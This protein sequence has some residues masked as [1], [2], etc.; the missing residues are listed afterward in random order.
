MKTWLLEATDPGGHPWVNRKINAGDVALVVT[1]LEQDGFKVTV[2]RGGDFGRLE[3]QF[4]INDTNSSDL[5]RFVV[6]VFAGD[7]IENAPRI[8]HLQLGHLAGY[9]RTID[10]HLTSEDDRLTIAKHFDEVLAAGRR[11]VPIHRHRKLAVLAIYITLA[12]LWT[13]S[14]VEVWTTWPERLLTALIGVTAAAFWVPRLPHSLR[15][16]QTAIYSRVAVRPQSRD[17]WRQHRWN[18]KRDIWAAM[19]G[20]AVTIVTA[21]VMGW[22]E[23]S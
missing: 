17:E 19:L 16:Q 3:R 12:S 22:L 10:P 6:E 4:D 13:W 1:R 23:I 15:N 20:G 2:R 8:A 7:G 9:A 21:L 11:L 18:V 5:D 14:S